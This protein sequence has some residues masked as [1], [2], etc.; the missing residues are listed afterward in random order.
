LRA[1][2]R[3]L[4]EKAGKQLEQEY[5]KRKSG[6]LFDELWQYTAETKALEKYG[7]IGKRLSMTE[8]AVKSAAKRLRERYASILREAVAETVGSRQE[9]EEE[10]RF[11]LRVL[12]T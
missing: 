5:R 9:V 4:T 6:V 12:L 1:R 3:E 11:L 8:G 7:D 10:L 2:A